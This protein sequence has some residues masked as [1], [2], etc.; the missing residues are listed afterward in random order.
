MRQNSQ[1]EKEKIAYNAQPV[2]DEMILRKHISPQIP[3]EYT[4]GSSSTSKRCF[5]VESENKVSW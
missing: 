1:T 5:N 4:Q 3:A 2:R